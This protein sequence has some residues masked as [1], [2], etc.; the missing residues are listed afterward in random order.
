MINTA[1]KEHIYDRVSD[2]YIVINWMS[3]AEFNSSRKR[4]ECELK[5]K[6]L[7]FILIADEEVR[8]KF[9]QE[10]NITV[11][12]KK[13]FDLMGKPKRSEDF[14]FLATNDEKVIVYFCTEI[15]KLVNKFRKTVSHGIHVSYM[16]EKMTNF[17]LTFRVDLG[18][19]EALLNQT[20]KYLKRL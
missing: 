17:D 14:Q 15:N 20:K 13:S 10:P 5:E 2:F 1:E 9:D 12:T 4:V 18:N 19:E 3:D 7:L 8:S 6:N 16:N 11:L